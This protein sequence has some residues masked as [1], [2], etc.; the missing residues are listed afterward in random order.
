MFGKDGPFCIMQ[1]STNVDVFPSHWLA[2]ASLTIFAVVVLGVFLGDGT[3]KY[4]Y[5][6][7]GQGLLM[8]WLNWTM[9]DR[10]RLHELEPIAYE[11]VPLKA[12]RTKHK[13]KD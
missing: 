10:W 8:P 1:S 4:G 2:I 6:F 12:S 7:I 11:K 13:R 3:P 9:A 5:P